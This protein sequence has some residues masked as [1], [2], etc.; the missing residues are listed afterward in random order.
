MIAPP[1]LS[2]RRRRHRHYLPEH[3]HGLRLKACIAMVPLV[4]A[5]GTL[6]YRYIEGWPWHDALYMT[7]TTVTTVGFKEVHELSR[8]GQIFTMGLILAGVGTIFFAFSGLVEAVMQRNVRLWMERFGMQKEIAK[9]EKHVIV[10]G[11][12]RMG[13]YVVEQ[14]LA[15][16]RDLVVIERDPEAVRQSSRQDLLVVEGDA[17]EEEALQAAGLDRAEALVAALGEDS[18]NL[19]LAMTA[20]GLNKGL[21]LIVRAENPASSRKFTRAGADHVVLPHVIGASHVV[22][23]LTQPSV[24]DF[25]DLVTSAGGVKMEIRQIE[26]AADS[27]LANRTIAEARVHQTT[28]C[29]I[30]AIRRANQETI[31]DPK[32][33][34]RLLPGDILVAVSGCEPGKNSKPPA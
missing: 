30:L 15:A 25:I 10:C 23:L 6:G 12:G 27:L 1:R 28:G 8:T 22:Q 4:L 14:L 29:M 24:V 34:T 13:Q 32:P 17:T 19:L 21:H 31:F 26:I 33:D 3:I 2:A 7:V 16:G 9:L 18:D 5:C 20:R 11:Y